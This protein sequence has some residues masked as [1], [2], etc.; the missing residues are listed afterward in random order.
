MTNDGFRKLNAA[1]VLRAVQDYQLLCDMLAE[2]KI[3]KEGSSFTDYRSESGKKYRIYYSFEE[4]ENFLINYGE[5]YVDM[6][7]EEM[8]VQLRHRRRRAASKARRLT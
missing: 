8:I 6:D 7:I 4:I 2:G 1:V 3:I 5:T